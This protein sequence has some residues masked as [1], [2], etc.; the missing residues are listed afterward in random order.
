VRSTRLNKRRDFL[1]GLD[2][3]HG[4]G[5]HR[6]V[7]RLVATVVIANRQAGGKPLTESI[8]QSGSKGAWKNHVGIGAR[9][10]ADVYAS[11]NALE[12]PRDP[13]V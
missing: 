3:N 8:R 12:A 1:R 4:V 10:P 2:E 6:S 13:K 5:R 11:I 9:G 7:R